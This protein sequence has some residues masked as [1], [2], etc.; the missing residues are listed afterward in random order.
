MTI[1][2]HDMVKIV[3]P[4]KDLPENAPGTV[5]YIH[6]DN[7]AYEVEFQGCWHPNSTVVKTLMPDEIERI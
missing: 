5:V 1:K 2:M 3:R 7:E 6:G 4:V